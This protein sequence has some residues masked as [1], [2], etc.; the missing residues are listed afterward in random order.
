[1]TTDLLG[2]S[3][4]AYNVVLC[5]DAEGK[6]EKNVLFGLAAVAT[7]LGRLAA[8]VCLFRL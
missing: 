4:L 7:T 1:M 3:S 8:D 5:P 2:F 6:M